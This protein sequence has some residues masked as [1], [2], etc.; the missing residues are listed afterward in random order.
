MVNRLPSR[1][2][3]LEL[4][5]GET[6][7]NV[8]DAT[9]RTLTGAQIVVEYLVRRGVPVA[10]GIPGHGC[11]AITDALLDRRDAI[12]TIQVMHEQSAVHLA[13]GYFRAT[14]TPILAFTSIGPGAM[15]TLVGMGTA[16]VDSTAVALLTGSPHTYMRGHGLFQEFERR[17]QAD[18]PRVFEPVVKE[19]WQPSRV[20]DLPFVLQRAWN[21]M[22]SGRPGPVLLDIPM[23][24]QAESAE[25]VMPDPERR[26]ARGRVRRAHRRPGCHDVE[27]QGCDR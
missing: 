17:H 18:N 13:D 24:V 9:A 14:G 27:R 1:H 15:N 3:D 2:L 20:D 7:R 10:A 12:R 16:Y 25:V 4:G 6:L 5:H 8:A 19:W 23:D 26:E 21:A 11:W 22:L